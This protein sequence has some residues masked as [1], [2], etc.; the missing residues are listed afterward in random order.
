M[1]FQRTLLLFVIMSLLVSCGTAIDGILVST[2]GNDVDGI[3]LGLTIVREDN[4][5]KRYTAQVQ[6]DGN[7]VFSNV[8]IP[9]D[10]YLALLETEDKWHDAV[11]SSNVEFSN[12]KSIHLGTVYISDPIAANVQ[13][14]TIIYWNDTAKINVRYVVSI[15]SPEKVDQ[16][17][18]LATRVPRADIYNI[19]GREFNIRS[20]DDIPQVKAADLISEIAN[21][22]TEFLIKY[23]DVD[24]ISDFVF[25]VHSYLYNED[26]KQVVYVSHSGETMVSSIK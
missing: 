4:T 17:E 19:K 22:E 1:R 5:Q 2:N 15:Y 16:N 14:N 13:D 8:V 24:E 18:I 3:R 7:F 6:K 11:L 20:I 25:V 9:S 23:E 12:K 26:T 10:R 21:S